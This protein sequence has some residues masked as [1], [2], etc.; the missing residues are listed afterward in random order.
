MVYS[1]LKPD[2]DPPLIVLILLFP[3]AFLHL[4]YPELQVFLNFGLP[5]TVESAELL[6]HL[7]DLV[8]LGERLRLAGQWDWS[9]L[10]GVDDGGGEE[11]GAEADQGDVREELGRP[12]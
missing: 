7:L 10:A 2:D 12:Q 8:V 9:Y 5:R 1:D 6:Y 3:L 4:N 11:A